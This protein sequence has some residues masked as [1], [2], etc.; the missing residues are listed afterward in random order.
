M[1]LVDS[2]LYQKALDGIE[3]WLCSLGLARSQT[4]EGLLKQ[5]VR[6]LYAGRLRRGLPQY[7]S[8]YGITPYFMSSRNILHDVTKAYPIPSNSIDRYQSE[9]VFEHVPLDAMISM[10]EEIHRI[11][12]PGG[13]FRLSLPDYNFD[14]YRERSV[15][16]ACGDI[17]F[18]PGGKGQFVDG[19]VIDGGHLWFPT[20]EMV[21]DL[22]EKSSFRGSVSYLHYSDSHGHHTMNPIDYSLGHIQRTPDHDDRVMD[23]PRPISIVVDLI[24]N[25]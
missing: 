25:G 14:G 24:K 5:P 22:V 16:N 12:K 8:H 6:F 4:W 21:Q 23:R 7:S 10:L 19:K 3:N 1:A 20:I 9:D 17:V 2:S 15:T 18:D 13:L 11:L